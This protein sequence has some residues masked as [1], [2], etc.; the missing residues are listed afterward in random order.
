M[1]ALGVTPLADNIILTGEI[2]Y[3]EVTN[4]D[5]DELQDE[6]S[7]SG[8]A[9]SIIF[10]YNNVMPATNLSVPVSF[11]K[12]FEGHSAAGYFIPQQGDKLSVG[13]EFTYKDALKAGI[14]YNGYFGSAEDNVHTDRDF[15]SLNLKY[16]F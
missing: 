14:T 15:I 9:G 2:G 11:K 1:H 5:E 4:L 7:G 8:M 6:K 12:N 13:A 10:S 3:N 16:S